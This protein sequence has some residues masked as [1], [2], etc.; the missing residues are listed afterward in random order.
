MRVLIADDDQISRTVVKAQLSKWGYE[1][2]EAIDGEQAWQVL[3][4]EDSPRL[5]IIDWM[6][7]GL[8]G[9]E[10][11]RRLRESG[12]KSYHYIILL[13]SR[14]SKD[15]TI[16]GLNAG[17]DD[18]ITKPYFAQ[19]LE[20]RLR[21]GARILNLQQSLEK[22]LEVQR[23]QAQHD[24]LTG[25]LNHREILKVLEN[26][27]I[28][29]ERQRSSMAVIMGDLDHFKKVNDTYGHVTGDAVLIEVAE[30]LRKSIRL[31]DTVGRYGGEEFLLVLP[32]CTKDEAVMIGHRILGSIASEPVQYQDYY[33]PVTISIG[34]AFNKTGAH[35]DLGEIVQAADTAMYQAKQNGRNRLELAV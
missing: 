13:T 2:V 26:E 28:R 14:D 12:D 32:G 21:A 8:D 22:A 20:V 4:E 16:G 3:Q 1:V 18:Y 10:L 34:L 31:Y 27:L 25:I 9:L 33:I 6:M 19:E 29:S 15:D 30:R 7:P 11:C 5:V 35:T 24:S 23:Y 17:A